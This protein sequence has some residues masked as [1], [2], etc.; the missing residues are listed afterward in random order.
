MACPSSHDQY[1]EVQRADLSLLVLTPFTTAAPLV[2]V[3]LENGVDNMSVFKVSAG[4]ISHLDR[5]SYPS[6]RRSPVIST[7]ERDA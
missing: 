6:I 5:R 1:E 7:N 4:F 3:K 2:E